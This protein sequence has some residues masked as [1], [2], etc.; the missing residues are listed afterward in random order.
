MMIALL[1]NVSSN[2]SITD[3]SATV[4]APLVNVTEFM[5]SLCP[6]AGQW[7]FDFQ[8]YIMSTPLRNIVRFQRYM[9]GTAHDNG[10][11]TCFHGEQENRANTLQLCAKHFNSSVDVWLNYTVCINGLCTGPGGPLNLTYC[12]YQFDNGDPKG[13]A[14]EQECANKVGLDWEKLK[15]C[16]ASDLGKKLLWDSAK[17]TNDVGEVYGLQGLPV[18]HVNGE[19]VSKFWDCD[20]YDTKLVPL[21]T[22]ICNAYSGTPKPRICQNSTNIRA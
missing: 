11:V 6:C 5:E 7:N 8:K 1:C 4:D 22:S 9:D 12:E 3:T 17:Y 19:R 2:G 18:V 13:Y 14:R 20:S 10:N 21:I 16:M 15:T